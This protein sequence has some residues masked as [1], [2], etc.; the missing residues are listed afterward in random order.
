MLL[1]LK[2]IYG[3]MGIQT[4]AQLPQNLSIERVSAPSTP[5]P[6][7]TYQN[8]LGSSTSTTGMDPTAPISSK[9]VGPPPTTGFV[10]KS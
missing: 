9:S 8:S 10:R 4:D 5:G 1:I 2:E 6:S 3:S 7:S